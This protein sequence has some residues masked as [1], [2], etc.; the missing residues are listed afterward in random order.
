MIFIIS[1]DEGADPQVKMVAM[2]ISD[3]LQR[4]C[5]RRC[6]HLLVKK[7]NRSISLLFFTIKNIDTIILAN[8]QSDLFFEQLCTW[9]K[10]SKLIAS[11]TCLNAGTYTLTTFYI[12]LP[13]NDQMVWSTWKCKM[14]TRNNLWNQQIYIIRFPRYELYHLNFYEDSKKLKRK[15]KPHEW[16][17]S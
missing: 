14:H 9:Q 10:N 8:V 6:G 16:W 13:H 3:H 5:S 1:S 2:M 15:E 11:A 17:Y 7:Q 4:T 12:V